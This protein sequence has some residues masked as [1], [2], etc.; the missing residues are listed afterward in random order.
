MDDNTRQG[1]GSTTTNTMTTSTG[2]LTTDNSTVA[3][4]CPQLGAE[5]IQ[6]EQVL[7]ANMQ[8][9]VVEFAMNVP[10][11]K[12]DIE[13]VVDVFVKNLVIDHIA[14]IPD[15][16]VVRGSLEVKVMYVAALPNQPVHA[17]EQDN[18][19]FTRDIPIDGAQPGMK[20]TAD[21]TVEFIQYDFDPAN[22]RQVFITI[23]LKIWARV[24]TVTDMDVYT[25]SPISEVGQT[26]VTTA[27]AAENLAGTPPIS[28]GNVQ[29]TEPPVPNAGANLG[30]SGTATVT[31]NGVNVR[32]GPGTNFPIITKVDSGETVSILESAFG[33]NKVVL[34]DGNTTGWIAGWL[35]SS[36]AQPVAPQG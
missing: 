26:E 30:A 7:G 5:T 14:V 1:S 10:D 3:C 17:F 19:R 35:M 20:A 25:L 24:V 16:I 33:W 13:Q 21:V 23:V 28:T 27:S 9:R 36:G 8:Q 4:G 18:V 6:V 34:S 22:P 2:T 31:G 15:K 29:V 32:T 11:P 12:P